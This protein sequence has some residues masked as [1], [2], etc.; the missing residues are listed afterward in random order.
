[1]EKTSSSTPLFDR[2]DSPVD[3]KRLDRNELPALADELRQ[4]I[5]DTVAV[6]G[7]HLGSGMGV[8][9]LTIAL[10]YLFDFKDDRLVWDVGH[11][12]YPHKLLT[13]RKARVAETMSYV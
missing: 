2:I 8:V 11:Q 9:E 7:G 13:E 4:V 1:M 5:M 6:T 10:H 3:L 12:C